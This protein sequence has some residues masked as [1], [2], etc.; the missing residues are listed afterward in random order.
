MLRRLSER[1]RAAQLTAD[2]EPQLRRA[3]L[4]AIDSMRNG[5]VLRVIVER[6]ERG[7]V[8]GALRVLRIEPEAFAEFELAFA[9]AYNAG[10]TAEASS[11][12]LRDPEGHRIS[13][14]WNVRDPESEAWLR[15]HSAALV[16]GIV[17]EQREIARRLLY[18]GLARGDNPRTTALDLVG[19][20]SRPTGT[21]TGGVIGLSAPHAS[22]VERARA[23]LL[24][25]D[26]DGMWAYLQLKRRD[27]RL[28]SAIRKALDAGKPIGRADVD[29]IIGR[30]SD[31]YLKLR[32]D[33][34]ALHETFTALG[35]SRN[36]AYRQAIAK[37]GVDAQDVVKTWRHTPQEHPRMQHVAMHGQVVTFEQYF[38]APDGTMMQHPHADSV[39]ARHTLGCKCRVD[40]KIDYTGA[41]ARRRAA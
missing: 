10:G 3:W 19:R 36:A 40:Y 22:A 39:P 21:R 25:G 41:L 16:T 15:N 29:R 28:D 5:V 31:S 24:S 30:L 26:A 2:W 13:F 35:Q 9:S 20:V 6:L 23:A 11:V 18:E 37:G 32:A 27:R 14:R 33:T 7:D 1:E 4:A 12:A 8:D 34:I 17:E 38:V